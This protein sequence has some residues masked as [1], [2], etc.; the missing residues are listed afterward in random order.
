[1]KFKTLLVLLVTSC[2]AWS[3]VH[4]EEIPLSQSLELVPPQRKENPR[5]CAD[6][7]AKF[8]KLV[9][10]SRPAKCLADSD[11]LKVNAPNSTSGCAAALVTNTKI[12][13]RDVAPLLRRLEDT[14]AKPEFRTGC[15]DPTKAWCDP[16]SKRCSQ[17]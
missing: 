9:K 12:Y 11:C 16:R 15:F 17:R 4:A 7:T 1:M 2:T 14:C 13:L 6:A 8:N 5:E 10:R 3:Q